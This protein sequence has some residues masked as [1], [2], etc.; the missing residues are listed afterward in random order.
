MV[1]TYSDVLDAMVEA[2]KLD[3]TPDKLILTD[4][5]LDTFLADETFTKEMETK[6]DNYLGKDWSLEVETGD[7]NCLVTESGERFSL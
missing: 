1:K 2:E 5:S 3:L 4:K 6:Q 7:D